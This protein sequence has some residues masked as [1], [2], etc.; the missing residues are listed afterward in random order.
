MCNILTV[1]F[2]SAG[3]ILPMLDALLT[4]SWFLGAGKVVWES[5]E[6]LGRA[7][8]CAIPC[9]EFHERGNV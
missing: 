4:L 7:Q 2:P 5:V 3:L 1:L 9:A 6:F 8:A